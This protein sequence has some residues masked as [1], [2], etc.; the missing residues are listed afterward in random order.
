MNII[1]AIRLFILFNDHYNNACKCLYYDHSVIFSPALLDEPNR[2][3]IST[4][5]ENVVSY[6]WSRMKY[7]STNLILNS[8]ILMYI[9]KLN[10]G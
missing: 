4:T 10:S 1:A 6:K 5:Y 8:Q 7:E 9:V 2:K 3:H